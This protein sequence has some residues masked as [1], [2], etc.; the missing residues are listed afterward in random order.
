VKITITNPSGNIGSK[1]ASQLL[2]SGAEVTLL[3]RNPAKLADLK[4]RGARIIKGEQSDTKAVA[5]AVNGSDALLWVNPPNYTTNDASRDAR[6]NAE[7]AASALKNNPHTRVVLISSVGAEHTSG[8]GPIVTLNL[9]E[10]ILKNA[11]KNL[12]ILR[13]NYFMENILG[14]LDTIVS[15]GAIYSTEPGD[16]GFP[17]IA[18]RDIASVASSELLSGNTGTRIID[19]NGPENV[20]HNQVAEV[21]SRALGKP[22]KH[23]V[24]TPDQLRAGLVAAGFSDYTAGLFI[25][26]S[27]AGNSGLLDDFLGDELRKGSTT[28]ERF[29]QEVVLPAYRAATASHAKAV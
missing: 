2:E 25:E 23:V 11:T 29:A 1:V 22:V 8:T 18:T 19:V 16:A 14:S 13:N 26:M 4:A 27:E 10:E 7:A 9:T 5:E 28:F 21:L 20:S 6:K 15:Q 3:G 17:Q 12:T 24:V